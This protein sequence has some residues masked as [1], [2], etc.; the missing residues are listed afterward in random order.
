MGVI[1]E[2]PLTP[3]VPVGGVVGGGS[4]TINPSYYIAVGDSRRGGGTEEEVKLYKSFLL[5]PSTRVL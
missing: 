3:L 5:T 4:G 1:Q 2:T